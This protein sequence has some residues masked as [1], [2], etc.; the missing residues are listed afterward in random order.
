MT[1]PSYQPAPPS[2]PPPDSLSQAATRLWVEQI[3]QVVNLNQQGKQN[4]TLDVTLSAGTTETVIIDPRISAF[5]F[6]EF[7]PVTAS[8]A[9]EKASGTMYVSER[10]NGEATITHASDVA[11][12]RSFVAL[13]KG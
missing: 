1:R 3:A 5:S 11:T 7:M 9:A 2:Y 13:I 12:D 6:I 8:A 4:D 10:K